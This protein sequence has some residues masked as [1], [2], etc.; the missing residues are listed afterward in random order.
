MLP[1]YKK[2]K[3]KFLKYQPV[4]MLKYVVPVLESTITGCSI[5]GCVKHCW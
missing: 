2:K 4:F 3:K 1:H 5:G